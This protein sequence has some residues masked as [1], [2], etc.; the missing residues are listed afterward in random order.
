LPDNMKMRVFGRKLPCSLTIALLATASLYG[1]VPGVG[2]PAG[3]S[4]ALVKLFGSTTAFSARGEMQVND[5][6]QNEVAYWPMDFSLSGRKIR[7]EVD[8]TQTRN[9][10]LPPGTTAT[11]KKI[12]M[13]EVISIIR[14]DKK[15]VSVIYPDQRVMLTRPLPQEDYEGSNRA[16]KVSKTVLGKETIDGHPCVKNRVVITDSSGHTTEALT[17]DATDLKDF[18]IQIQTQEK[19]TTSLVRFKKV[20]FARPADG[21]FEPPRD[22]TEYTNA[23]DLKLGVMK[24]TMDAATQK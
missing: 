1:Q 12:G 17:W 20:Q 4:A 5:G 10:D 9:R 21:L 22:F 18:P 6:S 15:L 7:I 24:K 3:M 2:G 16:P 13:S 14:P 11:L 23:E 8:L 19:D